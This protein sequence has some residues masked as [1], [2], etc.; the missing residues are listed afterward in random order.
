VFHLLAVAAC[1]LAVSGCTPWGQ[2]WRNS[3]KVGPNYLRPPAAV[4]GEWID[5]ESEQIRSLSDIDSLWWEQFNDPV[6]NGLVIQAY[7]QNLPLRE[8][9]FRVLA[10]RASYNIKIGGFFPQGQ[11]ALAMLAFLGGFSSATSMVIVETIALA[12]MISNHIIMPA[13]LRLRPKAAMRSDLR[14]WVL[15]A[16]RLS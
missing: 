5:A 6:L 2:Y 9:G 4:E 8:A 15:R 7:N 1:S 12:T 11:G 3:M 10:A 13:W 16:R 14:A